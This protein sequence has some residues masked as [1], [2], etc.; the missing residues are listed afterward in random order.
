MLLQIQS[1]EAEVG[2]RRKEKEMSQNAKRI[3]KFEAERRQS[4]KCKCLADCIAF[5]LS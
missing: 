5:F 3:R 2:A 1:T 4:V